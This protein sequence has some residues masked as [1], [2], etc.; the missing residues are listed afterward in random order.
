MITKDDLDSILYAVI[1]GLT[2]AQAAVASGD[3]PKRLAAPLAIALAVC[4][5]VNAK[6][7]KGTSDR[8]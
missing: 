1:A 3:L 5:A 8:A 4:I 7:S 2:T 6:R